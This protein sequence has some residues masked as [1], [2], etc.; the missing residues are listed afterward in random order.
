M[1]GKKKKSE[2]KIVFQKLL[3]NITKFNIDFTR[4]NF[5]QNLIDKLSVLIELFFINYIFRDISIQN[6]IFFAHRINFTDWVLFIR[7]VM[8][9]LLYE[10]CFDN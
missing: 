6:N 8:D 7:V 3:H 4:I 10:L 2:R 1:N 5:L 9:V